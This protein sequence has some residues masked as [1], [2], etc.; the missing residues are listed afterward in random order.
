MSLQAVLDVMDV[1]D[2]PVD[3]V[4][5]ADWLLQRGVLAAVETVADERGSTD[6]LQIR[7]PGGQGLS[8]G[9][10]APTVGIIGR[11]GGIGARPKQ[12]G[13]V[14]DADGAIAA[15]AVAVRLASTSSRGDRLDGDVVITTHICANAPTVDRKP[16]PLMDSPVSME[17]MNRLEVRPEMDVVFS[18]DATKGNRT[19]NHRGIAFTP[20]VMQGYVLPAAEDL[21]SIYSNVT[22]RAP[23]IL[24]LSTY[25]ITAYGNG[26]PHINSI[27]QPATATDKPV[28]GVALTAE[29]AVPGSA[30]GANQ[31]MD[32]ALATSFCIEA[33][34]AIGAGRARVFD[35]DH[36]AVAQQLYGPLNQLQNV[37]ELSAR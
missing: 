30:T 3:G 35:P 25:D 5:V 37:A 2:A 16:V 6:F 34:R 20:T 11:L 23:V 33:A 26:L 10:S 17:T 29:S 8:T 9:G 15:L 31:P 7:I 28:V 19:L 18:V 1:L 12:R 24:P 32:I 22:G 14:S 13:M 4:E 27:V 21:M 36:F